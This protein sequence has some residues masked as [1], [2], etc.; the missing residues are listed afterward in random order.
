[1]KKS[2]AKSNGG[3]DR[4]SKKRWNAAFSPGYKGQVQGQPCQNH[5]ELLKIMPETKKNINDGRK[6]CTHLLMSH[7][8]TK[9]PQ[10]SPAG[11]ANSRPAGKNG[12]LRRGSVCQA[13][14]YP[15]AFSRSRASLQA[16]KS[17]SG[18]Q[19]SSWASS[20]AARRCISRTEPWGASAGR[21]GRPGA[22]RSGS[23]R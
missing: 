6:H 16:G 12:F 1:M 14:A 18:R 11:L 19:R 9:R 17:H 20:R 15:S 7:P 3:P 23:G 4:K 8:S 21:A 10:K 13:A 5:D 2:S 22:N